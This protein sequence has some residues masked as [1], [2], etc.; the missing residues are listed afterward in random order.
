[1]GTD[2]NQESQLLWRE[3]SK[4]K[5]EDLEG[6]ERRELREAHKTVEI[7][8]KFKCLIIGIKKETSSEALLQL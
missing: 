3:A 6:T 8:Y 4:K 5:K 1:M 2:E 7:N